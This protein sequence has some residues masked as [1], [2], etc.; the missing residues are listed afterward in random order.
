MDNN[1]NILKEV[2]LVQIMLFGFTFDNTLE[3]IHK[4]ASWKTKNCCGSKLKF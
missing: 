3:Q 1:S 4:L 2:L